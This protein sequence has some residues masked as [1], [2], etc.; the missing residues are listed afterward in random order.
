M[1]PI[2]TPSDGERLTVIVPC[3]NEAAVVTTTVE[4]V[5]EVVRTL[6]LRAELLLVDDGSVDGTSDVLRGLCERFSNCR[7]RSHPRNL[8]LG[9]AVMASYESIPDGSWVTVMPGDNEIIFDSI[10]SLLAIRSDHDVVLGYLGNPVIRTISRRAASALFTL[11]VRILYGFPYRYLNGLKLYRVEAFRG[12]EV[13]SSGHG[14]NAELLAKAILRNPALRVGEAPFRARGRAM[15]RS[16]AFRPRSILR[17]AREAIVG[18][19]SV[20]AYRRQVV[21]GQR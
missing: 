3:L 12:I 5:Q 6:P 7:M 20:C 16:K 4:Q 9:R 19:R 18:Y 13:V 15:G 10:R 14:F 1:D 11:S 17:S 2:D 21:E 8:G